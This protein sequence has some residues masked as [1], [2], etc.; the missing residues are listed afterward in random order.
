MCSNQTKDKDRGF[1]CASPEEIKK[2]VQNITV[3]TWSNY[4]KV[5]FIRK[6]DDYYA[7]PVN[8]FEDWVRTD[9]LS[10]DKVI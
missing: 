5:D 6:E 9:R 3:A 10:T 8:R 2:F 7:R 4:N 1:D